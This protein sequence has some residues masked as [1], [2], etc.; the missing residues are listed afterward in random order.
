MLAVLSLVG[1]LL[2]FILL[3][4]AIQLVGIAPASL[5][6]GVLPVTITLLGLKTKGRCRCANWPGRWL[7]VLAGIICI[8]IDTFGGSHP[9]RAAPCRPTGRTGR[10]GCTGQLELVCCQQCPL[11]APAALL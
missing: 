5:I 9:A 8:N 11:S 1:N 2:Y 7:M 6:V 4:A 10:T 3:A